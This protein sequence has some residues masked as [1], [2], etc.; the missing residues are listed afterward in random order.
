MIKLFDYEYP[1]RGWVE[2]DSID[3]ARNHIKKTF[4]H[5]WSHDRDNCCTCYMEIYNHGDYEVWCG[6]FGS[7]LYRDEDSPYCNIYSGSRKD[8]VGSVIFT[9]P[10]P[11]VDYIL[12]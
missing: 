3:S 9:E 6:E 2:F 10:H 7:W 8:F 12:I 4:N 11:R 5:Y 1:K